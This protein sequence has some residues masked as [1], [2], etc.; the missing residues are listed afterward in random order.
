[1]KILLIAAVLWSIHG[2]A[3]AQDASDPTEL[4]KQAHLNLYYSGD[5]GLANVDMLITNKKG[6]VRERSFVMLRKDFEEGGEQKYFIYF[7]KPND[8]RRTT[9][10]VWK[11]PAE[12]D[13]R[14]LFV[15]SLDLVKPISANDK[16]SSFVGS[17]FSYE[18]VSGRHWS[19]DEHSLLRE[20]SLN[21]RATWVVESTPR[22]KDY[23][24]RKLTW[25]DKEY[26]LPVRE[27]YFDGDKVLK[28]FEA[29]EVQDVEGFATVTH[30]RMSTP[31]KDNVT[32]I[33][34]S[35]IRYN[36]GLEDEVFSERALKSPPREYIQ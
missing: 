2:V 15:P 8:V 12:D 35:A 34:F 13:A 25:I 11:D 14:W 20:E 32:D 4:M 6:N 5:D 33:T 10:M 28:V 16:K 21:E 26:R 31:R 18:D 9:F 23:F 19:D 7:Q 24:D 3:L 36:V 1:M 22:E 27:E 30:R 29:V 17:D